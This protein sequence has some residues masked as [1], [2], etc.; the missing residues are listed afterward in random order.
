M[1][2]T[3]FFIEVFFFVAEKGG[4]CAGWWNKPDKESYSI[5]FTTIATFHPLII[6]LLA[7]STLLATFYRCVY[8]IG[9]FQVENRKKRVSLCL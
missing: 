5:S 3:H 2:S 7:G 6:Y 4:G 1:C 9:F 8:D